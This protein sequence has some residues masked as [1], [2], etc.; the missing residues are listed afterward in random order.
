[1]LAKEGTG[2]NPTEVSELDA[3]VQHR[4]AAAWIDMV[5][6]NGI[7]TVSIYPVDSEG[8]SDNNMLVFREADALVRALRSSW[9]I[10]G[11]W[12]VTPQ[13]LNGAGWVDTTGGA[14][15]APQLATCNAQPTTCSWP[16]WSYS[17]QWRGYRESRMQ[18][19]SFIFLSV[20]CTRE[21]TGDM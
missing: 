17:T 11:D 20:F 13:I 12:N 15:V 10:A 18:V 2:I 14:I 5:Q 16:A 8:V 6:K 9:S 1:M 21:T 4:I 3:S 7:T 19:R